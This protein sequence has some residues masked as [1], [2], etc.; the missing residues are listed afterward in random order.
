MS[1]PT[2]NKDAPPRVERLKRDIALQNID[3]LVA[4]K[5]EVTFLLT[6]FTPIIYS[7]PV[8]VIMALDHDPILLV[9]A[10][11]DALAH[12]SPWIT[13]IRL[14]GTWFGRT[15]V[16]ETWD[17]ALSSI[18]TELGVGKKT[19]G[20]EA[21][22]IPVEFDRQLR[23]ALP[24]AT[25]VD[26]SAL[27]NKCRSIKDED[28]IADAR[29]AAKIA[30]V[31]IRA[32]VECLAAGGNEQDASIT[33]MHAMNTFW[34]ANYPE[35]KVCTFGSLEGGQH[36]GLEA[37]VL[38]GPRKYLNCAAPTARKPEIGETVSVFVWAV[39]NGMR[40]EVERTVRVG[41]VATV[42]SEAI[43]AIYEI[44]KGVAELMK[45][46]TRA[47][48]LYEIARRGFETR[49]Y[50]DLPGRI[51]HAIGLGNHEDFSIN[52]SSSLMLM[53]GMIV[54][55]EPHI[56]IP[57]ICSTQFSDTILITAEGHEYLT[58]PPNDEELV[59]NPPMIE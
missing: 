36:N 28:E 32:A 17:A 37:W 19:V 5:P 16:A 3:V 41:T 20:V 9:Y 47:N 10:L 38:S 29:I 43:R 58:S 46:G 2:A 6:G 48:T 27:I 31:G 55:L 23:H 53:P 59:I 25:F 12:T 35:I 30:D 49:G 57:G 11:R 8:I 33:S 40:A 24:N 54:T 50:K 14:Y 13:D 7:N 22:F 52:A 34:V 26:V 51:G 42:E 15:P 39:A 44:R 45:P 56:Q 21:G 4:F 18:L 1:L